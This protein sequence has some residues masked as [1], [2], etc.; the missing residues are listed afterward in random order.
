[1]NQG[2]IQYG[3]ALLARHEGSL[4]AAI[5]VELDAHLAACG[6][7]REVVAAMKDLYDE[8]ESLGDAVAAELPKI[9]L[10]LEILA[11]VADMKAGRKVLTPLLSDHDDIAA[12]LAGDLDDFGAARLE[13]DRAKDPLLA[14]ELDSLNE[15]VVGVE[16][17]GM[18][19]AAGLPRIDLTE[20]ILAKAKARALEENTAPQ[21]LDAL[22]EGIRLAAERFIEASA[23]TAE[24]ADLH[25]Y[26]VG[27]PAL[28]ALLES[29]AQLHAD[30]DAIALEVER[31]TPKIDLVPAVMSA[32][33]KLA[34]PNNVTPMRR[35][36]T[37][38]PAHQA[39]VRVGRWFSGVAAAAA[40]VL[41]GLYLG[42]VIPGFGAKDEP[43]LAATDK[44]ATPMQGTEPKTT[45]EDI[46][47]TLDGEGEQNATPIPSVEE[48]TPED[49]TSEELLASGNGARTLKEVLDARRAAFSDDQEALARLVRWS[50]LSEEEARKLIADKKADPAAILGA[51][52]FLPADEA[53][54]LLKNAIVENPNDPFLRKALA[55]AYAESGHPELAKEQLDAWSKLDPENSLPKYLAARMAFGEGNSAGGLA[56]LGE[57]AAF[58]QGSLYSTQSAQNRSSALGANGFDPTVA[59]FLAGSTAGTS[60]Y[61]YAQGLAGDL[62]DQGNQLRD[63]GMYEDAEKVYLGVY[64]LGAQLSNSAQLANDFSTA[65]DIQD[66]SLQALVTLSRIFA[67]VDPALLNGLVGELNNGVQALTQLLLVYNNIF[68]GENLDQIM[69]LIAATLNGG[70]LDFLQR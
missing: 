2:C 30:L 40:L 38:S 19:Q 27:R 7:C 32:V 23:T 58:E 42:Q 43:K 45:G 24:I 64:N 53:A 13:R 25:A 61:K 12:L 66:S 62:M 10:S 21:V 52:E 4:P 6:A 70:Q 67:G 60:D 11:G 46:R 33:R 15:V 39:G 59:R 17:L 14:E 65:Y 50:S 56:L 18:A 51:V 29:T 34:K 47:K 26:A 3:E 35:A 1:L 37:A 31:Q 22:P 5:A 68:N 57:A 69:A 54:A 16:A 28:A 63:A 44:S 36:R 48:G 20:S 9:D 41:F 8:L 49:G 55:K